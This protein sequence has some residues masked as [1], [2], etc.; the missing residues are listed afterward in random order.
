MRRSSG[1]LLALA[2]SL[3]SCKG[4]NHDYTQAREELKAYVLERP[5]EAMLPLPLDFD[6]KVKLLGYQLEPPRAV[7]AGQRV[8]LTLYWQLTGK[9][10]AG[11]R[12]YTHLLDASGERIGSFDEIGPLRELKQGQPRLPPEAW[13]ASKVYVDELSFRVPRDVTTKRVQLVAGVVRES[14]LLSIASGPHDGNGRGLIAELKVRRTR[15]RKPRPEPVP[16]TLSSKLAA[17]DAIQVD[18]KLEEPAWKQAETLTLVDVATGEPNQTFPVNG[19]V[20]LVWSNQGF[21]VGF[22]VKDATVVGG[23]DKS[24]RDPHLWT[25]DAVE[26]MVDPEGDGDNLD[27]YEIQLNPQNL[28][29]DSR[30]DSYNEPRSEPDG[31]FGHQEWSSKVKSAVRVHGTLDVAGDRDEGYVVEAL[32]P[33]T[34]FSNGKGTPP[35]LGAVWRMNFYAMQDNGGVAWSPILQ[36][37]NFHRASRFGRVSWGE[38]VSNAAPAASS[39]VG[40]RLKPPLG[41]SPV[42]SPRL[43]QQPAPAA[44]PN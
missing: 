11:S 7:R 32:I 15:E 9:V 31:P 22:E 33:W 19:S 20:K 28:V 21:Y 29:F 36:Q 1:L 42:L 44:A 18:G 2:L 41:A 14:E 37:G 3:C 39:P 24:S 35:A 8:S 26:I 5:P 17:S 13:E 4:R 38:P 43:R 40:A 12:L 16:A 23:F 6:G 10:E 27:Y 25:R 30:F 34:A